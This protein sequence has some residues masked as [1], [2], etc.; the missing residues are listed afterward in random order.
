M[1]SANQGASRSLSR[2]LVQI[3]DKSDPNHKG[4][5]EVGSPHGLFLG[6]SLHAALARFF[7]LWSSTFHAHQTLT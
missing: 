6:A 3:R 2:G 7:I 4:R 5:L 1:T